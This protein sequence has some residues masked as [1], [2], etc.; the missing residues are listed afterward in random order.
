M[1]N[2]KLLEK[3]ELY[4]TKQEETTATEISKKYQSSKIMNIINNINWVKWPYI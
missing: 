1:E 3:K 4:V 2:K